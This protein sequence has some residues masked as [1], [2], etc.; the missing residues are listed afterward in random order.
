MERSGS[1]GGAIGIGVLLILVGVGAIALRQTGVELTWPAWIIL[2]GIALFLA[3]FAVPAPAGSGLAAAGAITAA[4]GGLLAFQEATDTYSTW[5]YAWA[6]VAPGGV[7]LGLFL[8]GILTRHGDIARGGFS[9]MATGIVLFLVGFVFF[10]GVIRLNEGRFGDLSTWIVPGAIAGIGVLVILGALIPGPWRNNHPAAGGWQ[11]WSGWPAPGGG[12]AT[13]G[14]VPAAPLGGGWSDGGAVSAA[15][16]TAAAPAAAA[17]IVDIPLAGAADAEVRIAFGA[18][19]LAVAAAQPGKLAEGTCRGGTAISSPGPGRVRFATPNPSW[20]WTRVPFEWRLGLTGEV[21]LRLEVET[22]AADSDL[23]LSLLRVSD[24]RIRTGAAQTR[25]NLPAAAGVTRVDAEGGAAQL[26]FRVPPG[27]SARIH[28][29]MALGSTDV[30]ATRF[31]R[32][33]DGRGWASPDFDTA[34]NRVEIEVRGGV[35]QVSVA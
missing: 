3:A 24:L 5:A 35:G 19:R 31:P 15:A 13:P 34:P 18:G 17:E 27:V 8:Y 11:G 29:T 10:E 16:T 7:G 2:P 33:P 23:D 26:R 6:L 20:N 22:G 28:S 12:P 4:V 14:G 25:V 32:T 9:A 21:P 1:R 30:D